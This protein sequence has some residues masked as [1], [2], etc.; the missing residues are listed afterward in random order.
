MAIREL[1]LYVSA[2]SEMDAECEL[3]GR[4]LANMPKGI[5]WLIK[6]TPGSFDPAVVDLETLRQSDFFLLLLGMDAV[7]PIGIEWREAHHRVAQ[8]YCYHCQDRT[9]SPA[10]THFMRNEGIHWTEYG[11]PHAFIRHFEPRLITE[12]VQGTP[13]YGLDMD[14][15]RALTERLAE[16]EADD[17]EHGVDG[18]ADDDRRRGAGHGGVILRAPGG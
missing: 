18:E 14:D 15:I 1:A 2:A 5:R 16:L 17:D 9:P 8:H 12:L 4:M 11:T 3:L 10:A 6:R 13:G 7:A